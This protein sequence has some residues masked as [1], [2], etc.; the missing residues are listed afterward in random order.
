MS[1]S[2]IAK[3]LSA[4]T[5]ATS[6]DE[7]AVSIVIAGPQSQYVN[8]ILPAIALTEDP[9]TLYDELTRSVARE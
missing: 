2:F 9:V 6:D 8:E 4:I 5:I 3:L 1:L 7:H